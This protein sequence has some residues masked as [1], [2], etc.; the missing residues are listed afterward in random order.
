M[1]ISGAE[2]VPAPVFGARSR[3]SARDI[4]ES[5]LDMTEDRSALGALANR[6][7]LVSLTIIVVEHSAKCTE[8][9][10]RQVNTPESLGKQEVKSKAQ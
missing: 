7:S 9:C 1:E 10:A 6:F 8:F 5:P 2:A 4:D 3:D